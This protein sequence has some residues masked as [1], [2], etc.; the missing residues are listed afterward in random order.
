MY[1]CTRL[2]LALSTEDDDLNKDGINYSL[3]YLLQYSSAKKAMTSSSLLRIPVRGSEASIPSAT[4]N[5]SA[6]ASSIRYSQATMRRFE[7][8]TMAAQC[9]RSSSPELRFYPDVTMLMRLSLIAYDSGLAREIRLTPRARMHDASYHLLDD[10][11][12]SMNA[13]ID[14]APA[15]IKVCMGNI[16]HKPARASRR[17]GPP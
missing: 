6:S 7:P 4:A 12:V 17:Y 8:E 13:T 1:Q 3:H 9:A 14:S 10:T 16:V 11:S 5:H 15:A 2:F